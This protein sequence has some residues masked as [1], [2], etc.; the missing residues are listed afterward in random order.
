MVT[1]DPE[2]TSFLGAFGVSASAFGFSESK[3]FIVC[4]EE[5]FRTSQQWQVPHDAEQ[6]C[7]SSLKLRADSSI[8]R[9]VRPRGEDSSGR[10]PPYVGQV[11]LSGECRVLPLTEIRT[12]GRSAENPYERNA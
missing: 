5:A 10:L 8:I 9:C 3:P 12:G 6:L 2:L 4:M 1:I 11:Y 7:R